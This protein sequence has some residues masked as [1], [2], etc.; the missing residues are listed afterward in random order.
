MNVAV[1]GRLHPA[2]VHFPVALVVTAAVAEAVFVATRDRR[3]ETV[4]RTLVLAG[5][6][7]GVVAAVTG[8]A[9]ASGRTFE[10][11][12]LSAFSVHRIVAI[13]LPVVCFLAAALAG[14]S[15]H[16]GQIWELWF[17]R[18]LLA[19]GA[20]L[21]LVAGWAGGAISHGPWMGAP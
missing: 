16:T 20:V 21:A 11:A 14:S 5:A 10:P 1:L 4:A 13:A 7:T 17:Y 15:R 9:A 2:L 3:A 19:L 6:W 8:F 18:V 12:A